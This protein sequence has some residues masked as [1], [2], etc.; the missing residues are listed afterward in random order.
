MT[1]QDWIQLLGPVAAGAALNPLGRQ[2]ADSTNG[3]ISSRKMLKAELQEPQVDTDF[4]GYLLKPDESKTNIE[5]EPLKVF[6][7]PEYHEDEIVLY[8]TQTNNTGFFIP[9]CYELEIIM[10][11]PFDPYA[12]QYQPRGIG[13]AAEPVVLIAEIDKNSIIQQPVVAERD[14]EDNLIVREPKEFRLAVEPKNYSFDS[15]ICK[16]GTPGYYELNLKTILLN[17]S[18]KKYSHTICFVYIDATTSEMAEYIDH[19]SEFNIVDRRA[20]GK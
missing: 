4:F 1:F 17:D 12:H 3:K 7:Q 15:I 6:F 16:I 10:Y 9:F 14:A 20:N 8:I 2:I 11:E 5:D 19:D 18:D 13:N